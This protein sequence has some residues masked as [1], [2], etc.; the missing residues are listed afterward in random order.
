MQ[1]AVCK[2]VSHLEYPARLHTEAKKLS[3]QHLVQVARN[4]LIVHE[5][6]KDTDV[7]RNIY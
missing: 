3:T 7:I 6:E 2:E 4:S 1:A 5:V